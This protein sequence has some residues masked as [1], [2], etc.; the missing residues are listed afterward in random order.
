MT[1]GRHRVL[2]WRVSDAY[3][4][5]VLARDMRARFDDFDEG[6]FGGVC[7]RCP[8]HALQVSL[9]AGGW[10]FDETNR[11]HCPLS[12]LDSLVETEAKETIPLRWPAPGSNSVR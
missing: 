8:W 11:A 10:I 9:F 12:F 4:Y 7:V 1:A 6:K 5:A 2:Q 3:A